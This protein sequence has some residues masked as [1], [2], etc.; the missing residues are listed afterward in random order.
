[1]M[2]I[3]VLSLFLAV[4]AMPAFAQGGAMNGMDVKGMEKN[5]ASEKSAGTTHRGTGIVKT[6]DSGSG[7]IT[8]A[9]EPIKTL[10]WPAMT[11]SFKARDPKVLA[12]AKPGD[13]VQ[14]TVVQS[15]KDYVITSMK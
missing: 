11:M 9:H 7:V 12:Q 5:G 8:I 3:A 14:F 13:H 4:A 15:G 2:R 6:I 1:M 10:G